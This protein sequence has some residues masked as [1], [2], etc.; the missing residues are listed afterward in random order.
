MRRFGWLVLL[1]AAGACTENVTAPGVC[2]T[3]C[4]S[5][6]ISIHD[7]IFAAI[8]GRDSSFSGYLQGYQST[9]MAAADSPGVI[10]SRPFFTSQ[11]MIRR[12]KRAVDTTTVPISVDSLRLRLIIAQRSKEATNLRLKLFTLPVTVDSTSDFAS[13]DPYFTAPPVDSVSVSG[14]LATPGSTDTALTQFWRGAQGIC[15]ACIDSV[16]VD[17]AGNV[18]LMQADSSLLVYLK[19]DTLQAPL[20]EPDSGR[21]AFGIRVAADSFA[22]VRLATE[23]SSVGG[24]AQLNWYFHFADSVGTK[25]DSVSHSKQTVTTR[26]D[27]FVFNPPSPAIDSN[28]TVGG[29]PSV[30]SLLRVALPAFLHDSIDLVRATLILVP[31]SPVPGVPSDSF[32][33]EGRNVTTDLGAKSPLGSTFNTTFVHI[34][35][36]DTVRLELTN[37][38]RAWTLDTTQVTSLFLRQLPEAASYTQARFYSSRAPAFRP[39]LHV[40]YVKR[41]AFGAP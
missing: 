30:R 16:R 20:S 7:T 26:F 12:I 13:L 6:S 14:L 21:L 11:T 24:G 9:L 5:G 8:I 23:Q 10:D 39:S 41:F 22:S 25:P 28:L 36:A 40:T 34:G 4:P 27:S 31:V 38:V 19:L 17:S 15:P 2:P 35:S 37:L 18:L 29:V 1:L 33:I 32:A 3:F